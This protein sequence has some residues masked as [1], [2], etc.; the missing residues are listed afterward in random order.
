MVAYA[1][2]EE[3]PE[4]QNAKH[5]AAL[6]CTAASVRAREY[7]FILTYANAGIGKR[8][9]GGREADSKVLGAYGR[10]MLNEDGKLLLD[11]AEDNKLALRNTFFCILQSD[12]SYTFQSANCSEGQTCLYYILTKQVN[13]RLIRCVNIRRPPL[14][15]PASDHNL[16]YVKV[17]IS[18]RSAPN[19][20]KRGST[21]ETP[22]LVDLRRLM[23]DPNR[24][25]QVAKAM[26]DAQ[27]PI[28]D[29]TCI[30][31][32]ATDMV[33]VMLS[34]AAEILSR[35]KRPRVARSWCVGPS[36]E[37]E[38]NE[39]WQYREKARRNL[40]AEPHNSNHAVK[41]A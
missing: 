15:A 22:K 20:M 13:R 26:A 11:F 16:V 23:T 35:S 36:V 8:G 2:T 27:P 12:V 10:D 25:C 9:E 37:A 5:M 18:R 39:A 19:P 41:M 33:D 24:R 30:S 28:P 7:V 21:K 29:S 3:A 34:T 40:C 6:N 14:E 1:P 17:R 38:M 31:D 32:I 4:G